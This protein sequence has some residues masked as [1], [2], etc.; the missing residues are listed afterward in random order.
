MIGL[1]GIFCTLLRIEF[2]LTVHRISYR[3]L[4][5]IFHSIFYSTL[6]EYSIKRPIERFQNPLEYLTSNALVQHA[7]YFLEGLAPLER[8]QVAYSL[9]GKPAYDEIHSVQLSFR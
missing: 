1:G 8:V 2:L 6:N 7:N 5:E 3:T 4:Y 9:F